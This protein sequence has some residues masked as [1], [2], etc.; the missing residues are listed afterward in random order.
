MKIKNNPT[1][2]NPLFTKPLKG[3]VNEIKGDFAKEMNRLNKLPMNQLL[4]M[5]DYQNGTKD[6]YEK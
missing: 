2:Q 1:I 4:E 3:L 6:A 5:W